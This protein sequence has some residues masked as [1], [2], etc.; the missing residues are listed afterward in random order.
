M[1]VT[2]HTTYDGEIEAAAREF[3]PFL[4]WHWLKAQL[5][6]ESMLDPSARSPVGAEGIGQFMPPTWKI[7]VMRARDLALPRDAKP[8]DPEHAIRASAWYDRQLWRQWSYPRPD[9]DRR[10]L[11]FAGYNAGFG[12]LLQAQ[13]LSGGSVSYRA[14]MDALPAITGTENAAE[15]TTYVERIERWYDELTGG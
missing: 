13:R 7:D 4:D 3:L 8:T 15:T 12:N 5:W 2:E 14:I 1:R 6:Q 10:R 9:E 11:M